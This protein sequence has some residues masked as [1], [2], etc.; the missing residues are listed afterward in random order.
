MRQGLCRLQKRA[1]VFFLILAPLP[2]CATS[3]FIL[4]LA[5]LRRM[6]CTKPERNSASCS[7][8]KDS[9]PENTATHLEAERMDCQLLALLRSRKWYRN[10]EFRNGSG[11]QH[12]WPPNYRV[13]KAS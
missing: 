11:R 3:D 9:A 7:D 8:E 4:L 2:R 10:M 5:A 6:E 13:H 12:S 1:E